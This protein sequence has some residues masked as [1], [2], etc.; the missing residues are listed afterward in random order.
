MIKLN[1]KEK[2]LAISVGLVLIIFLLKQF[3]FGPI[4]E[5]I[6][7]YNKEID[8][9]KLA[10]RKYMALEHNRAEILKAQKRIEGYSSLK[11]SDE[12]KAALVMSKVEAEAR[13]A[14]LQISDMSPSGSAKIKGG[15]AVYRIQIR[16]EGQ[17]KNVLDF[18][19]GIENANT[20]LQVEKITLA[21][22]DESSGVL[23]L[24]AI[25]LGV[26]F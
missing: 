20:L 2:T 22:K 14:K 19:S 16:A 26:S 25:V 11:G 9:A 12:D 4:Y 18:M 5:K 8:Q 6:G 3:I 10:M 1:N 21:N 15:A 13:K 17:M 24:D 7:V 23:K